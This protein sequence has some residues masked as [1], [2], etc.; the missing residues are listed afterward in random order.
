MNELKQA[1][2]ELALAQEQSSSNE[3]H[4]KKEL[5]NLQYQINMNELSH[6]PSS[7]SMSK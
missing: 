1:K 4:L 6:C 2:M 7:K 3:L 5:M